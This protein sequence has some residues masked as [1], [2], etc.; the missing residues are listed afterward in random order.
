[1]VEAAEER[2]L[3]VMFQNVALG[4]ALLAFSTL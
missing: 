2:A 4:D 1:M 3:L